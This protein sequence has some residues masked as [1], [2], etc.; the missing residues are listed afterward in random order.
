MQRALFPDDFELEADALEALESL[1]AARGLA[2]VSEARRRD[3]TLS[4][5]DELEQALRWLGERV[6]GRALDGATVAALF[7][8]VPGS[9][10]GPGALAFLDRAVARYALRSTP[11]AHGAF[12]DRDRRLPRAALE[13]AL[14]RAPSAR[15]ELLPLVAA[16]PARADLRGWLADA[17]GR[18]E[19]PEEAAEHLA[20]AL[21]LDASAVDFARHGDARLRALHAELCAARPPTEARELLLVHAWIRGLLAI[22][23]QNG[24][25]STELAR[26]RARST[27]GDPTAPLRRARRFTL[28]MFLDRSRR[29]GDYDPDERTEMQTLDPRLFASYLAVVGARWGS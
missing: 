13:L 19:R 9:G 21:L 14:G 10:L 25:I 4:N 23:P 1:D 16:E 11:S 28:L 17:C 20:C 6:E 24:W 3:P 22:P 27:T 12:V 18:E 26:L 29:P 7:L 2:R 15:R 5:L 8:A